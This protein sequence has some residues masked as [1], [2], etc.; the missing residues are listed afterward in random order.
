MADRFMRWYRSHSTRASFIAQAEFFSRCGVSFDHPS[1]GAGVVL[2]PEGESVHLEK[3]KAA[4]MVGGGEVSLNVQFWL[5]P[6]IDL[7]CQ[8]SWESSS[9]E[10]QTY[11]FEGLALAEREAVRS[12]LRAYIVLNC[13]DTIGYVV[14]IKGWNP[15]FN[16][17]PFFE[18]QA[19]GFLADIPI[20]P[21]VLAVKRSNQPLLR[22]VNIPRHI[23]VDESSG[24]L[25]EL[26][27]IEEC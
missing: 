3:S 2:D 10:V 18:G 6:D 19:S 5:S 11:Y 16:W 23:S 13:Q 1:F 25:V 21:D 9:F 7:T 24:C 22:T 26:R 12:M 27:R 17:D 4:E 20:C 14:D 15:D 8:F